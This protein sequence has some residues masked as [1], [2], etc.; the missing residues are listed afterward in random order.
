MTARRWIQPVIVP[1]LHHHHRLACLGRQPVAPMVA[2]LGACPRTH[3]HVISLYL[4]M[5]LDGYPGFLIPRISTPFPML[6]QTVVGLIAFPVTTAIV[7]AVIA[8]MAGATL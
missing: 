4:G 7:R 1:V 8:L 5:D 6:A 2:V 3:A